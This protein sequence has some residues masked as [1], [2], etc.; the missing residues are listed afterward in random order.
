M[1]P[2]VTNEKEGKGYLTR[3]GSVCRN[4]NKGSLVAA[5]IL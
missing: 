1:P 3:N 2:A 4:H 5:T